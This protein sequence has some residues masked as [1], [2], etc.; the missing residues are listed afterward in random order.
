MLRKSRCI[1]ATCVLYNLPFIDRGKVKY[2]WSFWVFLRFYCAIK[3]LKIF[4]SWNF[5]QKSS[6]Q[7]KAYPI[8]FSLSRNHKSRWIVINFIIISNM[9]VHV[10]Y[11][12]EKVEH[13]EDYEQQSRFQVNNDK[14]RQRLG[15][16]DRYEKMK[17]KCLIAEVETVKYFFA[18]YWVHVRYVGSCS[19]INI[20]LKCN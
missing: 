11:R 10:H 3:F 5:L 12:R 8:K 20:D 15:L 7:I 6:K 17:K 2:Y 14:L 19:E 18:S 1:S 9:Y 16:W 4:L 13:W